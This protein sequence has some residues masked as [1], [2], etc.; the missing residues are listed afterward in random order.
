MR[1]TLSLVLLIAFIAASCSKDPEA[2]IEVDKNSVT[3]G[4]SIQLTSCS[5]RALSFIW[6]FSGPEGATANSIQRSEESFSF[7][8]DTAGSYTVKLQ[9]FYRYSWLGAWD[10]TN[11]VITVN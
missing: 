1:L 6:S 5:K 3:V 8:F 10:T 9:A 4:E 2:C 7:S 11:T